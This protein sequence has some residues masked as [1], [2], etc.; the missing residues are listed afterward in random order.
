MSHIF[1]E[2][3]INVKKNL[4]EQE[5]DYFILPNSDEFF[6]EY[7]PENQKRI[8]Y[9]SGF[10]GSNAMI[11]IAPEKSKFFTDGRYIL[12]AKNE[13]NSDDYDIIN[14]VENP[15]LTWFEVNLKKSQKV[16]IDSKLLSVNFVINLQKIVDKMSASL[17][18]IEQNPIDKIWINRDKSSNSKI[19]HH[20]L[21]YS[22]VDAA[23]KIKDITQNLQSDALL[24]SHSES[25]CWLLNIRASDVEFAPLLAAY[26][27]LYRDGKIDLFIDKKRL[28]RGVKEKL[29]NVNYINPQLLEAAIS[30]LSQA[31]E[32]IQIDANL[33][34]FAIYKILTSHNLQILSVQDPILIKKAI[35][36]KT[37]IKNAVKAHKIDGL[38]VVK[39]LVWLED[40][41][42]KGVEIDEIIAQ[43]KLLKFRQESKKFIYPSFA[44]ISSFAAN[45]AVIHYHSTSR[46]NKKLQGNSLYLVDSG[47]Q[48]YAGT[49]DITRTIAIG[50]PT[51]DMIENFTLVLK[52]H[53]ALATA[54]FD[55]NTTGATLDALARQYLLAQNKDYEHGTGHGVGSFLS[56]HEGPSS[57]NKRALKQTLHE[58]MIMSNEPG[59]YRENEY[60][61]RIENLVLVRGKGDGNLFFRNLTLVPID[62]SLIDVKKLNN[63]EKKW[64][65]NYHKKVFLTHKPFLDVGQRAYLARFYE[66]YKK[67][68]K[69]VLDY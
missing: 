41:L 35:K 43:N 19:F 64:L 16:A 34:N 38:A 44:T 51:P 26:A 62:F 32:S 11:I 28:K 63:L 37:E 30:K 22:G 67:I 66:Y 45:G 24:I 69:K 52:G 10:T 65:F 25:L 42:Q 61:I 57:I 27:I 13:L 58:G 39:F 40:S 17:I 2:R 6:L 29:P 49:T 8:Q 46:T 54:K 36:N 20:N 14:I 4:L 7:L 47:G 60:G 9:L 23:L 21:R 12:Q 15:L 33:T 18:F 3:L 48:Y 55:K 5:I 56:V 1:N 31:I 53:I 68:Y 50:N 59:F